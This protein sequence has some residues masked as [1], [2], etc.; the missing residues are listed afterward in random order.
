MKQSAAAGKNDAVDESERVI[1]HI[2]NK[3]KND[4][5]PTGSVHRFRVRLTQRVTMERTVRRVIDKVTGGKR[6]DRTLHWRSNSRDEKKTP[7]EGANSIEEG[8]AS[9]C[10]QRSA[11]SR[12]DVAD[13]RQQLTGAVDLGWCRATSW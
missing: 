13:D 10:G 1:N 9:H 12:L 6:N 8:R 4:R 7:G 3:R 2:T 11:D 5:N